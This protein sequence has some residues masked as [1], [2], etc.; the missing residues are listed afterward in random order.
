MLS[1][2]KSVLYNLKKYR[3]NEFIVSDKIQDKEQTS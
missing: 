3:K 2:F 1:N